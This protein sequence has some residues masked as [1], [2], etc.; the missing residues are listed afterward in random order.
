MT[1][2]VQTNCKPCMQDKHEDCVREN[3][4]CRND[5]HGVKIIT[6]KDGVKENTDKKISTTDLMDFYIV[7]NNLTFDDKNRIDNVAKVLRKFFH[8]LTIRKTEKLLFYNGKIY[9]VL[10][11]ETI[12][13][14]E[15]EKLIPNCPSHDTDETI[16][17]IKRQTYTELDDFDKDTNL[18]TVENGILNLETLELKS[19]SPKHLSRVLLP[20]QYHKPE[21]EDIEKNLETT[22]FWKFLKSS[23]IVNGEFRKEDFETVLEIIASTIIKRHVDEK[24]FMFL[25]SGENGK[26]VCLGCIQSIIGKDNV[27]SITLQDIAEDKFMRANLD[28]MSANIFSDLEHNELRKTGKIK[29]ITSNEGIDF[30]E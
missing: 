20:V 4:L 13:K 1:L 3:C 11:A 29:A 10:N 23:F 5:N 12:I 26:S 30:G 19:H 18:I 21:H 2:A 28:G 7:Q 14:E 16:K 27:S 15:T 24:A 6:L 8:F 17:K 9:D 25:G 22:L